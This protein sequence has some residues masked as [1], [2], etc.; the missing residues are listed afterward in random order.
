[1]VHRWPCQPTY[2]RS[3]E[4]IAQLAGGSGLGACCTPQVRQIQAGKPSATYALFPLGPLRYAILFPR[5]LAEVGDTDGEAA[6]LLDDGELELVAE[7]EVLLGGGAGWVAELVG[8]LLG[9][10]ALRMTVRVTTEVL[11]GACRW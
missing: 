11:T 9:G 4:Q 1:M 8:A 10:A 2:C 7:V 3:S 5:P 6:A